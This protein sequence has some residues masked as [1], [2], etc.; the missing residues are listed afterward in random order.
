MWRRLLLPLVLVSLIGAGQ[1]NEIFSSVSHMNDLV[2]LERRLAYKVGDFLHR[3]E[4]KLGYLR[5]FLNDYYQTTATQDLQL[6]SSEELFG[7]STASPIDAYTTIKRLSVDWNEIVNQ[8]REP[9]W[10]ARDC[11]Y[12]GQLLYNKADYEHA[13]QWFQEALT[14]VNFEKQPSITPRSIHSYLSSSL[15]L[16]EEQQR[17]EE[18]RNR[19]MSA[20]VP[21]SQTPQNAGRGY[22]DAFS[23]LCRG[24]K[25]RNAS[26]EKD[27]FCLYDVPHPYFKIGPVKVEQMSRNPY[28]VQFYDVL[29]P[30]EIKAFRRM[31]DPQLERATV[32][33]TA[34]NTVSHGR[35][36]QVAWI[37]PDS[38]V[39]LDRVNARVA[40]LTGLSTDYEK[41][42]SEIF[43]YN[44]YGPGGHYE[45]HHDY[46]FEHYTPE[47]VI[48]RTG[49]ATGGFFSACF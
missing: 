20:E 24:E 30:Q 14:K 23:A 4:T 36:S 41:G 27:L 40:M 8:F 29:W 25:I 18:E 47:Q 13:T 33:D 3:M 21:C 44:S 45:P 2:S 22:T 49:V 34:K 32:R 46:L 43:Q 38:D 19:D 5:S 35:V 42:D 16:M 39:L 26:E 7:S 11:F 6:T 48:V 1:T 28:V 9:D 17:N 15:E 31:G 12:F 10:L 37:S